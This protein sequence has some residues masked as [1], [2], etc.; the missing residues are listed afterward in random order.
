MPISPPVTPTQENAS[1]SFNPAH[2][3]VYPWE[4]VL[5]LT[6]KV[7]GYLDRILEAIGLNT[8]ARTGFITFVPRWFSAPP[9]TQFPQIL[10]SVDSEE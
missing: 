8:E 6:T 3:H 10:A 9:H 2:A 4:S 7:T 1:E 5:V